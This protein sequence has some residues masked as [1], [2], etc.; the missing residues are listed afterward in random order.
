[1]NQAIKDE[2]YIHFRISSNS[3][4]TQ[5]NPLL[6]KLY[7]PSG[8][9]KNMNLSIIFFHKILQKAHTTYHILTCITLLV[10]PN[11]GYGQKLNGLSLV[12][13]SQQLWRR[14]GTLDDEFYFLTK[15]I[16]Y[17]WEAGW[18]QTPR[19]VFPLYFH[20]LFFFNQLDFFF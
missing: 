3:M 5:N 13:S 7:K 18:D 14:K 12:Y 9:S 4:P 1:M 10:Q 19:R 11:I 6:N 15:P 2:H 16:E 17:Q 20:L 8:S